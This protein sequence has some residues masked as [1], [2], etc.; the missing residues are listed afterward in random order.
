M[1]PLPPTDPLKRAERGYN[2]YLRFSAIGLQMAGVILAGVFC[3]KWLDGLVQWKLPV[4]TLVLSLLSI[5]GALIFLIK[6]TKT[7]D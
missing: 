2:A 3:G 7:K 6:E 4:F 1:D 5:A